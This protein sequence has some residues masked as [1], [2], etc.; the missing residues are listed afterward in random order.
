MHNTKILLQ[1]TYKKTKR[2]VIYCFLFAILFFGATQSAECAEL[3]LL[4]MPAVVSDRAETSPLMDVKKVDNN[5]VAVGAWGHI[6]YSGDMCAGWFQAKVPVSVTMTAVYFANSMKGWAVGHDGVV[7]NTEDGGKT[8]VKQLDGNQINKLVLDQLGHVVK[9]KEQLLE[10]QKENMT[11]E[12][13]ETLA[14]EIED[15]GY[16]I[17]DS[18]MALREGPTR[19]L[20]DLWFKNDQEGIIVG[21]FGMIFNTSDGGK[22]W[23]PILDRIENPNGYHYY[24][25]S[26]SGENL[27]I[28]GE[29]GILF[30]SKDFGETWEQLNLPYDGSFFGVV[31]NQEGTFVITFGLRGNICYS[32]D[33]GEVWQHKSIG[34]S[35]ISGGTWLSDNTLCLVAVDGSIY[36]SPDNGETFKV[37]SE[38]FPSAIAV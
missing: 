20:I 15:L 1:S 16:F 29:M 36:V 6:L 35:S 14:A 12:A 5:L 32:Q 4:Q 19:P 3:D 11:V 2:L 13:Q 9:D 27:F 23:K 22:S 28:A 8:W 38:K 26:R 21:V 25:I 33:G 24:G 10:K 17:S 31:G 30:R 34:R 18:A 7:L 37:L